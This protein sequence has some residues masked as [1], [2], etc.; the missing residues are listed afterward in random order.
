M[1]IENKQDVIDWLKSL[2]RN[3]P[4]SSDLARKVTGVNG[5]GVGDFVEVWT[6]EII[7]DRYRGLVNYLE[8]DEVK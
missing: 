5:K 3:H 4:M 6:D 8:S 2:A 1:I 7:R